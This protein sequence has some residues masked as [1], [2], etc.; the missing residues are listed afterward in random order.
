MMFHSLL[1]QN[2]Q[3]GLKK[4]LEKYQ[5]NPTEELNLFGL[6]LPDFPDYFLQSI[7]PHT[8]LIKLVSL[9]FNKLPDVP[10]EFFS[11]PNLTEFSISNNSITTL[12]DQLLSLPLRSLNISHNNITNS[13]ELTEKIG[14]LCV[15][16]TEL[17]MRCTQ[18]FNRSKYIY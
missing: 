8:S 13:A 12:P 2:P 5:N 6:G 17:D 7:A 1:G 11:I 9:D 15:N 14:K 4:Q 18:S 3:L 10:H 16:L